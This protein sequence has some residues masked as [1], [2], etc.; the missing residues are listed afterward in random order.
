MV[1]K[2]SKDLSDAIIL[3]PTEPDEY[4]QVCAHPRPHTALPT[5][6][7]VRVLTM[8]ALAMAQ[9]FRMSTYYAELEGFMNV[10]AMMVDL[11]SGV[12]L[13][14]LSGVKEAM[15]LEE[16]A[17]GDALR[18]ARGPPRLAALQV[19]HFVTAVSNNYQG[20]GETLSALIVYATDNGR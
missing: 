4:D 13:G 5:C 15:T 11:E 14:H 12:D 6:H 16:V 3:A 20:V 10:L 7:R 17:A 2:K 8:H 18:S 1:C 19:E 9:V